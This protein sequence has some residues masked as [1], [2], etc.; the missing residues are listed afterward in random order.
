MNIN[1]GGPFPFLSRP[2][3]DCEEDSLVN[4]ELGCGG[5]F[6]ASAAQGFEA[7]I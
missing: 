7:R 2:E 4:V 6:D 1:S 3:K 5:A